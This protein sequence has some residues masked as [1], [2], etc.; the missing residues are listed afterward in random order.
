MRALQV[1]AVM[2]VDTLHQALI[3]HTGMRLSLKPSEKF[4]V[5]NDLISIYI[6]HKQLWEYLRATE[7]GMV[8][9]F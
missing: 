7:Y 3:A 9:D 6:S 5:F 1:A 4:F 8:G 2:I